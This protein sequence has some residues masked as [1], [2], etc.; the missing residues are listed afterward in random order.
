MRE[1]PQLPAVP[2]WG[3]PTPNPAASPG[4]PHPG[5][6]AEILPVSTAFPG[7][8]QNLPQPP[9]A[10]LKMGILLPLGFLGGR[11]ETNFG[12]QKPGI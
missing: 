10:Y 1:R 2:P 8:A 7:K 6:R 3:T 4:Q 12:G 11:T 5:N 9:L